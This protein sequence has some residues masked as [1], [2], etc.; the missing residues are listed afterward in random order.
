MCY[1]PSRRVLQEEG[2][3]AVES[4]IYYGQPGRFAE[5]VEEKIFAAIRRVM[6]RVGAE[7]PTPRAA[8]SK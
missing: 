7:P 6:E 1:I 5:S 2:Y 3:E 8:S 4:M